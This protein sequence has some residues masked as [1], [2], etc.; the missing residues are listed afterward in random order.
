VSDPL[1]Q[2]RDAWDALRPPVPDA[3]PDARTRAALDWTRAAW[4]ALEAPVA[5]PRRGAPAWPFAL[6]GALA[7]AAFALWV[8][9]RP[10]DARRSEDG[11]RVAVGDRLDPDLAPEG[12]PVR[13]LADGAVELRR[14]RVRLILFDEATEETR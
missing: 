8:G 2:L 12:V 9:A 11:A 14:G 13:V 10:D 4:R 7:A 5:A 3:Q 6:A 1:D